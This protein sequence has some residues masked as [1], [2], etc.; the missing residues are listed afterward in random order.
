MIMLLL[1]CI[2]RPESRARKTGEWISYFSQRGP[3]FLHSWSTGRAN[4]LGRERSSNVGYVRRRPHLIAGCEAGE[5]RGDMDIPGP[6]GIDN[7]R[8]SRRNMEWSQGRA[9]KPA[10]LLARP[11]HDK[12]ARRQTIKQE[13]RRFRKIRYSGQ[14]AHFAGVQAD[15][16]CAGKDTREPLG[17]N[18]SNQR[19]WID[20]K[21]R[22]GREIRQPC[23]KRRP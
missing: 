14:Q 16:V 6:G 7:P 9:G 5:E 20:H 3:Q 19:P 17:G 12:G 8:G 1:Y 15:N 4:A 22:R 21:Q 2:L 10:A 11:R 13:P 23:F 18:V